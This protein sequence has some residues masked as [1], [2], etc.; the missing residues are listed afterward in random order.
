MDYRAM[1]NNFE[2]KLYSAP[3]THWPPSRPNDFA[4]GDTITQDTMNEVI[5]IECSSHTVE[6]LEFL[7]QFN[8]PNVRRIW[9]GGDPDSEIVTYVKLK[10]P[11]IAITSSQGYGP[12]FVWMV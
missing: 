9:W 6:A 5:A 1:T 10:Y 12:R 11:T 2:Y 8:L 4:P 3:P 7:L